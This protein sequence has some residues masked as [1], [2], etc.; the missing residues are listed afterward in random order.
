MPDGP[1]AMREIYGKRDRRTLRPFDSGRE[2]EDSMTT[3]KPTTKKPRKQPEKLQAFLGE[4]R[5]QQS[6]QPAPRM[7]YDLKAQTIVYQ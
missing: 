7:L 4:L 3:T 6:H 5:D 1:N 2:K